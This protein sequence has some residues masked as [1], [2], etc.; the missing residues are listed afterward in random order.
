[1][2]AEYIRCTHCAAIAPDAPL[3][4]PAEAPAEADSEAERLDAGN[5]GG[6]R[7]PY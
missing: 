6:L 4:P 1:V 7:L 2:S 5:D 3:T